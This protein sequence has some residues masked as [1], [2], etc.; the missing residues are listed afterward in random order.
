MSYNEPNNLHPS[1]VMIYRVNNEEEITIRNHENI[2]YSRFFKPLETGET[3]LTRF[4]DD[5]HGYLES[6]PLKSVEN[7]I[8][9]TQASLGSAR[10]SLNKKFLNIVHD[11]RAIDDAIQKRPI[12]EI[13]DELFNGFLIVD[14]VIEETSNMP[15]KVAEIE[16]IFLKWLKQINTILVKCHQIYKD[17]PGA[18]PLDELKHWRSV[19]I[20][21][22]FVEDEIKKK[23][24]VNVEKCLTLAK[25]SLIKEWKKTKENLHISRTKADDKYTFL[26]SIAKFFHNL[27]EKSPW[28][29]LDQFRSLLIVIKNVNDM[30]LYYGKPKSICEFVKIFINQ[31]VLACQNYIEGEDGSVWSQ[32]K[33]KVC[34]KIRV[35]RHLL[36]TF[37]EKYNEIADWECSLQSIFHE[38]SYMMKKMLHIEEILNIMESFA[39][40]DRIRMSSMEGYSK[41]MKSNFKEMVSATLSPF[42]CNN[43][44]FEEQYQRF[45]KDTKEVEMQ[46]SQMMIEKIKECPTSSSMLLILNQ[47]KKFNLKALCIRQQYVEV[48]KKL[49]DEIMNL[50]DVSIPLVFLDIMTPHLKKIDR[51]FIE[52]QTVLFWMSNYLPIFIADLN[53]VLDNVEHHVKQINDRILIIEEN[54]KDISEI[55]LAVVPEVA[56]TV[57]EIRKMNVDHLNNMKSVISSKSNLIEKLVIDMIKKFCDLVDF[58]ALNSK[59]EPQFLIKTEAKDY[60]KD[61][62]KDSD[63]TIRLPIDKYDWIDFADLPRKVILPSEEDEA[64]LLYKEFDKII[65]N[66]R[67]FHRSCMDVFNFFFDQFLTSLVNA[68]QSTLTFLRKY[69]IKRYE[70]SETIH[71][72]IKADLIMNSYEFSLQPTVKEIEAGIHQI[73]NNLIF[74]FNNIE[75]WGLMAKTN[76]R[77]KMRLNEWE[78]LYPTNVSPFIAERIDFAQIFGD[79]YLDLEKDVQI[80]I[81]DLKNDYEY[82]WTLNKKE[83]NN[84]IIQSKPSTIEVEK[85]L[86][87]LSEAVVDIETQKTR[88][89]D[90]IP[91][92]I[93]IEKAMDSILYEIWNWKKDLN[94]DILRGIKREVNNLD[95]SIQKHITTLK[96]PLKEIDDVHRV[97]ECLTIVRETDIE[98]VKQ[99]D[100]ASEILYLLKSHGYIVPEG[101]FD[102]IYKLDRSHSELMILEKEMRKQL[103]EI[104]DRMEADLMQKTK[105]F[106]EE[107]ESFEEEYHNSGPL[108]PGIPGKVAS[109]RLFLFSTRFDQIFKLYE[110]IQSGEK[111]YGFPV[112]ENKSVIVRKKELESLKK[113]YNLYND[114]QNLDTKYRQTKW[115]EVNVEKLMEELKE[116]QSRFT[117]LPSSLKQWKA[118][119]EL[120]RKLTEMNDICPLIDLLRNEAMKDHHWNNLSKCLKIPLDI[121]SDQFTLGTILEASILEVRDEIEDIG[122]AALKEKE[123]EEKLRQIDETWTNMNFPVAEFKGRGNFLLKG[124]ET[125]D[126]LAQLDDTL[127]VLNSLAANRYNEVFMK[128]TR[129]WIEKLTKTSSNLDMWLQVQNLW[130]YLEAVFMSGDISRQLPVEAKLFSNVD[131]NFSR[132]VY[133]ALGIDKVVECCTHPDLQAVFPIIMI[134]LE[135]CLKSLSSYLEKK[136]RLFPRFFFISDAIL[137]EI[138]GESTDPKAIQPHLI[139]LFD[140]ISKVSFKE[141]TQDQIE[142]ILSTNG[143][144]VPLIK[145]VGC[146]DSVEIW[147]G[148]LLK[149]M[150]NTIKIIAAD[151]ARAVVEKKFNFVTE[152]EKYTGQMG[153]IGLQILWTER[154]EL[155]LRKSKYDSSIMKQT[156]IFFLELLN[157][158]I[159]QTASELTPLDRIKYEAMITIHLHQRDIFQTL[160]SMKVTSSQNFE[161][162]KQQRFYLIEETDVIAIK[163]TNVNFNYQ[164]EYLGVTDR[165]VITPLTDRCYI[166]LAQAISLNMGG[167]PAGPAGT[168]KTETTKDM[169]KSLGKYVVVFNCSDQM[170]FRGLGQIF[171]GLSESGSWGCFDEFNRIELSVLS[172]AAQQI[173]ILL[174]A[175]KEGRQKFTFS[176]GESLKLNMEFGIFITMN[177]GYAGRQE[178][179]ENLKVMFRSVAMMVPDRQIIIRVKLASCGFKENIILA[180]KFFTLYKLCENQLSTQIHYD[181]G[182]RNI[183]SVLRTL[184]VQKRSNVKESEQ[185]TLMRVLTDMNLSK[186]IAEDKPIFLSLIHDLFPNVKLYK[187]QYSDLQSS[188]KEYTKR[189]NLINA[190]DWNLKVQQLYETCLVRHGIM[191]MGETFTGK[192]TAMKALLE[193]FGNIGQKYQTMRM[194]P[195]SITS[196]Q[197]FGRLDVATNE[198]TDGIF[199]IL[200]RKISKVKDNEYF[201]LILDGPVD[202]IWIE[203]LNSVLDDNKTLTLA[204][205]DRI[206]MSPNSKLIFEADNVD[207]ASPATVSRLGMVYLS[208]SVLKWSDILKSWEVKTKKHIAKPAKKCFDESFKELLEFVTTKL[209]PKMKITENAYARQCT[210]ILNCLIKSQSGILEEDVVQ[211]LALYSMIWSLGA[212]LDTNDRKKLQKY[213]QNHPASLPWPKVSDDQSI[214]DFFINDI[215][216]WEHWKTNIADYV[217]PIGESL[218]FSQIIIPNVESIQMTYLLKLLW[219]EKKSVLLIGE[220]GTGKTITIQQLMRTF[221]P[222]EYTTKT[223]NFSS[224][225]TPD[226]FQRTIE[227]NVDKRTGTTYGPPGHKKLTLFIDDL[228]MPMI[229]EWGDQT[230]NEIV[231]QLM[232]FDGFYSLTRLGEFNKIHDLQFL[233]AMINPGGGQNDIPNRLKRQFTIFTC[234]LPSENS[235]DRIFTEIAKG[236][237]HPSRFTSEIVDFYPTLVK[238]TRKLWQITKDNLLP[239]P[240]KFHYVFNLRD[241]SRIWQGIL[242]IEPAECQ[243]IENLLRLWLHET[244]RVM[245]DRCIV[246]EDQQWFVNVQ[247]DLC[248]EF[249][250]TLSEEA[251]DDDIYFVNFLR[252]IPE[253]DEADS[254]N[255]DNEALLEVPKVYEEVKNTDN[256]V[257]KIEMFMGQFNESVR[258]GKLNLVLFQD[259]L[260]H[261]VIISRILNMERGNALLVGIGGFGKRSLTKLA[262][263]IA[264]YEF[265][266]IT[267]TTGYN[268]TNLLEDIKTAYKRAGLGNGVTFLFTDADAV[269]ETFLD[270]LNNLL[271]SGEIPNL[272]SKEEYSDIANELSTALMKTGDPKAVYTLEKL[273]QIFMSS[274][275]KNFH[276]VLCFSPVG[277]NLRAWTIKFPGLL[278]GCTIDWF[279]DWPESARLAVAQHILKDFDIICDAK[280]KENLIKSITDIHGIVQGVADEYFE[281][282][283]R[284]V[285]IIPKKFLNFLE[286]YKEQYVKKKLQIETMSNRMKGGIQKL[287]DAADAIKILKVELLDKEKDIDQATAQ[288][289]KALKLVEESTKVA[290]EARN[291]VM[292]IKTEA[293]VLVDEIEKDKEV[294][295]KKLEDA[296]PALEEAA[297][298]LL[299]IKSTDISTV[300]KLAKPPHLVTLIMDAVLI[301]FNEKI[302][303]VSLDKEKK[304]LNASYKTS[305]K[306]M[307]STK[308][309]PRL[310]NFNK[311]RING[312]TMDLLVPYL[313]YKSYNFAAANLACGNVAGLLSWTIAMTKYYAVN[314]EVLPLK[315]ALVIQEAKYR[316]ALKELEKA[317]TML[318]ETEN[319]LAVIQKELNETMARKEVVMAEATECKNKL[320][321]ASQLISGLGEEKVRWS[322]RI[323]QFKDEIQM[324]VGDIFYICGFLS[325]AGAFNEEFRSLVLNTLKKKLEEYQVPHQESFNLV[326]YSVDR[327]VV[328]EWMLFGLP[329]DDFSIQ[330]GI[331]VT[332]SDKYPL[333]I[334][335]QS[336][337]VSWIEQMESKNGLIILQQNMRNFQMKMENAIEN[338]HVVLLKDVD[339]KIDPCLT[340][341]LD[342]NLVKSG[343][344]LKVV[345]VDKEVTWNEN[346]R[347]YI[348]TKMENPFYSPEISS[349]TTI[350]DFT[351]TISGLENQ[352]LGRVIRYEK[353]ELE[354]ERVKLIEDITKNVRIMEELEKNLLEKLSSIEGSILDDLTLLEMLNNSKATSIDIKKKLISAG[355]TEVKINS[356]REEYRSIAT[357]GSILYFLISTLPEINH[358]YRTSLA[359]FLVIIDKSLVQAKPSTNLTTRLL[360]IINKMTINIFRYQSRGL[361]EKHRYTFALLMAL[362]IDLQ[363]GKVDPLEFGYFLKGGSAIDPSSVPKNPFKWLQDNVWLSTIELATLEKFSTILDDMVARENAWKGWYSKANPEKAV[364][365]FKLSN[366]ENLNNF[367]KLLLIKAFCPDRV[368]SQSQKYI[369][370]SLGSD[371]LQ[372]I[373]I[374][375]NELCEESSAV[376]PLI[377][378]LSMGSDPTADIT[379][380]ARK[381]E[382]TLYSVSMGQGQEILARKLYENVMSEEGGWLLIQNSH[383]ALDYMNELFLELTEKEKHQNY[384]DNTRIWIT[385][386]EDEKYPINLLQISIKYSNDPPSGLKAGLKMTYGN[387][388]QDMLDFSNS[389][390]YIPLIYA[391]SFMYTVVQERRKYGPIGWNIPY[392]FN[393]ADWLS[394]CMFVQNH[395][396]EVESRVSSLNWSAIR[397]MLS[398]VHFGGRVTDNMDKR[399]LTAFTQMWFE[400]SIIQDDFQLRPGYPVIKL[401][402]KEDYLDYFEKMDEADGPEICGLHRNIEINYNVMVVE[403]ILNTA[404]AV[405]PKGAGG[406][407]RDGES[408]ESQVTRQTKELL[409]KLPAQF[410]MHEVELRLVEMDILNPMAIFLRQEINSMQYL[411]GVIGKNLKDLL[412]AID[413][414]IVMSAALQDTMDTLYDGKIPKAWEKCSWPTTERLGFWFGDLLKR[415]EFLRSWCF[416]GRPNLFWFAGLFNPNGFL[417]AI[418][419][420]GVKRHNDWPLD[421][422]ILD[423][424]VLNMFASD[425]KKAVKEGVLVHGLVLEGAGWD[426][427]NSALCDPQSKLIYTQMPVFHIFAISGKVPRDYDYYECPVY[428]TS[429][430]QHCITTL[431]LRTVKKAKE[432]DTNWILRGTALITKSN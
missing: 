379:E 323:E 173:G 255:I 170:D 89:F 393:S 187:S 307:A 402:T 104:S 322:E 262:T 311:D 372:P 305:L 275:K 101:D 405:Q 74:F 90:A 224:L 339:E 219:K 82:L 369:N 221:N 85:I 28:D 391:I 226:M 258:G 336:Q 186:L 118:Y 308:F 6:D 81:E 56:L 68:F 193:H 237:F 185:A 161:W 238:M 62:S 22:S 286:N 392:E 260:K 318:K 337:G 203:N 284:K 345:I 9:S 332:Q 51:M 292:V 403:N 359:Q 370:E 7:D 36:T 367:H 420:E 357:R 160:Y 257:K 158:L 205:G 166:T 235:I 71:P 330:N 334:D 93:S 131:L 321:A 404:L 400:N 312:E 348:T 55:T 39:V 87:E 11:L 428:R 143:E 242:Q 155:A 252:D 390:Y 208:S 37:E 26:N 147:L 399:L 296:R 384:P 123:I 355:K 251:L 153:I 297:Q 270:Y 4:L 23:E 24:F 304:F 385:S 214:F 429:R 150:Q 94:E 192:T 424:S 364:I 263:F 216:E 349:I 18:S 95:K 313:R 344:T 124:T 347:L 363:S 120:K 3:L 159:D 102:A 218:R 375:F 419:Q 407:T 42:D 374:S 425:C 206:V 324:L 156:N 41:K 53:K 86:D 35:S 113:L 181:F 111:L 40:L 229:N 394:S 25:S 431:R 165:L 14:I 119:E 300:R 117:R 199:S 395:L 139:S 250:K 2:I 38:K 382:V 230:T 232:E 256:C 266:S 110:T 60:S 58:P 228:N 64:L 194:N 19:I 210:D 47:Y 66:V 125:Q 31:L 176:D 326:N 231:R 215:G 197:M 273:I 202:T 168:G 353:A 122:I 333:L 116:I 179:P 132:I 430:R 406:A 157:Q 314:R 217:Q 145:L 234:A 426:R 8:R 298:A 278:S 67:F 154:S 16:E 13:D 276:L 63:T 389:K 294:A 109:D 241:I 331:L 76:E 127:L 271:T 432:K 177:P 174:N 335:P 310:L 340:N 381:H 45:L 281:R 112:S 212:L 409:Q 183:L 306:I 46:I 184:G 27:D 107:W 421:S 54:L 164:N 146:A 376:T 222:E 346:F 320:D 75:P 386:A 180:R 239:S 362:K 96:R 52:G 5:F 280:A 396:Q 223:L 48:V 416:N 423:N 79:F 106:E 354:Q 243:T 32:D 140:G 265:Y 248:G 371:F 189:E 361:Y 358:M 383:L 115:F 282:F 190:P 289:D 70:E 99:R 360:S 233:A 211:K 227:G 351:V 30:S 220:Q 21:Y 144:K 195:K 315:A 267:L 368:L 247:K 72:I 169:G 301:Y 105:D 418:R 253:V 380:L 387:L 103:L 350:V 249:V 69:F 149:E 12:C 412:L 34:E 97:F 133:R 302:E 268:T 338:G 299:T 80:L 325:Y 356:V 178:L 254:E 279:Q 317:E 200:F 261:L 316:T 142:A 341:V 49:E 15:K 10:G 84:Q 141:D 378:L 100:M 29:I 128:R 414:M 377:C 33:S 167:A 373:L 1:C 246:I 50:F 272:F 415:N 277:T 365:P 198:W 59:N 135:H 152:F 398:Q 422:V 61:Y 366:G 388:T 285:Y 88:T 303:K 91:L 213:I 245:A 77:K 290:E 114:I 57:D 274:A 43:R 191:V 283:R 295:E 401:K 148:E 182:L 138:L 269:D 264:G 108:I 288:A 163:I 427:K 240:A 188:I 162:Q 411:L 136:R 151:M 98:I 408:R 17:P 410:D 319:E 171:K 343:T 20:E 328:S 196:A 225:T 129:L 309:L 83:I 130:L 121:N 244:R 209:S 352:L 342:K 207:N 259:A 44:D 172:V 175:R 78:R 327:S 293:E 204:N 236:Y 413:G 92:T 134:D 397:Y 201:W 137:I 73:L 287:L 126:L 291:K 65:F 417:T 329:D